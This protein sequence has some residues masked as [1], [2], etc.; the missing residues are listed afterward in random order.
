MTKIAGVEKYC[1]TNLP[2]IQYGIEFHD[3]RTK[4]KENS[5]TSKNYLKMGNI[6]LT[7]ESFLGG[8]V[9]IIPSML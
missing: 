3:I 6:I 7:T 5:N 4:I 8:L 1:N 2:G 9:D